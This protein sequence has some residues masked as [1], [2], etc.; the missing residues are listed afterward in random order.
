MLLHRHTG[1]TSKGMLS[2]G[3]IGEKYMSKWG[4]KIVVPHLLIV[5]VAVGLAICPL[6]AGLNSKFNTLFFKH[7]ASE[8]SQSPAYDNRVSPARRPQLKHMPKW[9]SHFSAGVA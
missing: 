2:A 8:G 9:D 3:T 6:Y 1:V 4:A 5:I 7:V